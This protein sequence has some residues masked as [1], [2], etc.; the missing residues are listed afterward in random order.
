M[1]SIRKRNGKWQVQ[2]RRTAKGSAS[3]TFIRKQDAIVW[4]REQE[5]SLQNGQ[6]FDSEIPDLTI[7][8]LMKKYRDIVTPQKRGHAHEARRIERLLKDRELMTIRLQNA[9]PHVFASFRDRRDCQ[10]GHGHVIM[11]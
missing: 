1:A 3:K 10:T 5:I 6:R 8:C 2:I 4:A 7:Y 9:Q 11:T